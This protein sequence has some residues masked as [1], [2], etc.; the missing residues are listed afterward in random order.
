[1]DVETP[2]ELVPIL[3]SA[4]GFLWPFAAIMAVVDNAMAAMQTLDTNARA[5]TGVIMRI[6][7]S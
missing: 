5:L 2:S 7:K 1:M 6:R 4:G 3:L